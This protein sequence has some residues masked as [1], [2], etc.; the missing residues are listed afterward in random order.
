MRQITDIR[1]LRQ[2]QIEILDE[3]HQFCTF[4][5]ISYFLSSGTLIGAV[6]HKGYIPWDDDIDLYMPRK[7][8]EQFV[9]TYK[10]DT[11]RFLLLEPRLTKHYFYTFAKIVDT[12]TLMIEAW[13]DNFPIGVN[14]DIFPVDYVTDNL[15]VRRILF[16]LKKYLFR[17]YIDKRVKLLRNHKPW[18]ITKRLVCKMLPIPSSLINRWL[19]SI[20]FR[21]EPTQTVCNMTEM[22]PSIKGCFSA[23]A[24]SSSID[25]EFE[26]KRYKTMA[27]YKEYLEKT[28]GDYMTL[29][30]VEKRQTHKFE[31]YFK[32]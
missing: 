14:I 5:G 23:Q 9:R 6:R 4:H 27:G 11:D 28:Y 30:P 32:D 2:I 13:Y 10:S 24:I 19:R 25:I 22:G 1:D 17:I 15:V 3:I 8:Y 29:P 20:A 26:G 16:K 18:D 21:K 7:D 31:A 12:R